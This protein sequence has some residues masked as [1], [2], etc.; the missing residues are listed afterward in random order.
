VYVVIVDE[1]LG[2]GDERNVA[3]KAAVVEPV[4]ADGWNAIDE[5]RG[6]DGNNYEVGAGM[7]HRGHFA[8]EGGVS[9]LMVAD[10]LLVHP[11]VRAVVGCADVEKRA[12]A[13]LGLNVEVALVPE[14]AFEVEELGNLRIPVAGNL[15]G[16]RGSKIVLLVVLAHQVGVSI[17][18]VSVVVDLAVAQIQLSGGRGVDEVVPVAV[19]TGDGAPIDAD[20]EGLERL[21]ADSGKQQEATSEQDRC[22]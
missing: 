9:A 17:Q 8:V 22:S 7:Q 21:L 19:K 20:E 3:R 15:D 16:G 1:C 12:R 5:P 4:D 6:I 13:R 11:N 10:A 2:H 18:C 14:N